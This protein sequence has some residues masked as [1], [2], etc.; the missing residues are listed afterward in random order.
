V[1]LVARPIEKVAVIDR[2]TAEIRGNLTLTGNARIHS[3]RGSAKKTLYVIMKLQGDLQIRCQDTTSGKCSRVKTLVCVT[4][5]CT[6][7]G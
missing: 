3:I 6:L 2:E 7:W 5:T 4:M 1:K